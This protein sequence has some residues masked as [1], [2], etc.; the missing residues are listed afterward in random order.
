MSFSNQP[1]PDD[2]LFDKT[3]E[4]NKPQHDA[5]QWYSRELIEAVNMWRRFKIQKNDDSVLDALS[6]L[7]ALTQPG[8]KEKVADGLNKEY[9][10]LRAYFNLY[11]ESDD[12]LF[13]NVFKRKLAQFEQKFFRET[14]H[15]YL[16]F[17]DDSGDEELEF[18][19]DLRGANK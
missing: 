3:E 17:S 5:R 4:S 9:D 12:Y 13:Y 1:N 7:L 2:G 15:M 19:R 6:S 14:K 10:N 16:P 11:E 18:N 8:I